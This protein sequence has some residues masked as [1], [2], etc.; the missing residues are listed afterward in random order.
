[1][2]KEINTIKFTV[3]KQI[4]IG[5]VLILI[6]KL[7]AY[8]LTNSVG[9]LTDALESIVNVT[10]GFISLYSISIALKPKDAD[11]P[12]G[13]GKVEML[14]ASVEGFMIILAGLI[15]IYEAIKRLFIP[16]VIQQ[17]DIG[18]IIIAAGGF[19]NY[20]LGYYSIRVGRKHNSMALIAGGK[21]LHSDFYSTIGLVF[22][23]ILL[24]ITKIAWLDSAIALIF[25]S[26]IIIT[27]IK[28][29]KETTSNL[30]DETDFKLLEN[31]TEIL[32]E[33]KSPNW[34]DIHNLKLLKYGDSQHIDCDLTLPWYI[35]IKEAHKEGELIKEVIISKF[36]EIIDLNVHTDACKNESCHLCLVSEC[37]YREF[38]FVKEEKW[39][40]NSI[41][42]N[43]AILV[44]E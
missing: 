18:I 37:K 10:A 36:S 32:W 40:V 6:A 13:H 20:L 28:I 2:I 30:M 11:H 31:L 44:V 12:F 34:I 19:I 26:I 21:H 41:T 25:G 8:F 33:N 24:F 27:G 23:L 22:G 39:D 16:S 5:S 43:K 4:V 14:S 1:M 3:Q 29:L 35:N 42:K 38:D 17:L 9:I 7:G 15:I